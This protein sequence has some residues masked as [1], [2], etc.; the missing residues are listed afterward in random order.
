MR[1]FGQGP[2]G[3]YSIKGRWKALPDVYQGNKAEQVLSH[4]SPPLA[5]Y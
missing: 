5:L 2:F 4:I 1:A 3:D